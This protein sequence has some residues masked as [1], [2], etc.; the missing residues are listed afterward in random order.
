MWEY[1]RRNPST[2]R[3][4]T[5]MYTYLSIAPAIKKPP[6]SR[7]YDGRSVPPP[8]SETRNGERVMIICADDVILIRLRLSILMMRITTITI[9]GTGLIGGSLALA[10]KHAFPHVRIA[11]VDKPEVLRR[12]ERLGMIDIAGPQPADLVILATPVGEIL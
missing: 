3:E 9:Y 8:A 11:G 7:E 1:L 10:L 2:N 5:L 6:Y 12:A 4:C